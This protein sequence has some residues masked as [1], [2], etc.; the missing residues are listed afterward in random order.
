MVTEY[1]EQIVSF[2][3][4]KGHI[5]D[6]VAKPEYIRGPKV[7]SAFGTLGMDQRRTLLDQHGNM[8]VYMFCPDRE[9]RPVLEGDGLFTNRLSG[10]GTR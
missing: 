6:F 7:H 8:S 5:T 3:P 10:S 2:V 9:H 1:K 4:N